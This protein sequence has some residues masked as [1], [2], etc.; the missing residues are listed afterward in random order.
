MNTNITGFRFFF[1]SFHHRALDESSLSIRRVKRIITPKTIMDSNGR[2]CFKL[3]N[4]PSFAAVTMLELEI[5]TFDYDKCKQP[6]LLLSRDLWRHHVGSSWLLP[7]TSHMYTA[8]C[9]LIGQFCLRSWLL[10]V[11]SHMYATVCALIG[12]F[13]LR[14]W[15]LPV[16]SHMYTAVCAL[17]GQFCLRSWLLPVTS[18]M[19]TAVCALIGQFCLRSWLL[20]VTSHMYTAVCALIGQFCLRSWLLPVTSHMYTAVCALIGQFCLRSWLLPVT[21]HMYTAVC[22][23]I[24]QFCLRSVKDGGMTVL[25]QL[26]PVM[27]FA[28]GGGGG[29]TWV[30]RGAHTLVIKIKNTPKALISGQKSILILIKR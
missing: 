13:C 21:S 26:Q 28:R 23:L 27:L 29:G 7:V 19:Y 2:D 24:G 10:P 6:G 12:Q 15:L 3:Y 25:Y 9:A 16:T 1:K 5:Y 18:H 30:I 20:P 4:E 8:V 22:A 14:S 17:I 11:T